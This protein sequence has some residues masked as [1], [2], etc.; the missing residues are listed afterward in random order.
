MHLNSRSDFMLLTRA[1]ACAHIFSLISIFG[2]KLENVFF[3]LVLCAEKC[4]E[5]AKLD[6]ISKLERR[7]H[8]YSMSGSRLRGPLPLR[9]VER[10]HR[11]RT[12]ARL[13]HVQVSCP[14]SS[15]TALCGKRTPF[16]DECTP[17][18]CPG[19]VFDVLY[20]CAMWKENTV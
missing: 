19:L 16:K 7:M 8:A 2:L 9:Y 12:N 11:L 17:S 15:T 20:H 18:A 4:V 10:G 13:Q 5:A 14:M 3:N 1:L 6:E